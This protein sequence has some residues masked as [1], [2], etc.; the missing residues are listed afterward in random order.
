M[1]FWFYLKK[2]SKPYTSGYISMSKN[3]IR[4]FGIYS[5][6][7]EDINYILKE[8]KQEKLNIFFEKKYNVEIPKSF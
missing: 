2:T 1:L 5:F 4:N 6:S 3:Y 7:Q 8:D